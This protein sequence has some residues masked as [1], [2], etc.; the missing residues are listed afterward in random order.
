MVLLGVLIDPFYECI[1]RS[2]EK[3]MWNLEDISEICVNL[4]LLDHFLVNKT[5]NLLFAL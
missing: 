3:V 1:S 4:E 5:P 2:I